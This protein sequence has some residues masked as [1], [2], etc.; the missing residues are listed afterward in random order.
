MYCFD[1]ANNDSLKVC[2]IG[3]FVRRVLYWIILL[4]EVILHSE[5]EKG[6]IC[7]SLHSVCV[8]VLT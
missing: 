2:E 3:K 6:I 7:N 4:S 5:M 1:V 8:A